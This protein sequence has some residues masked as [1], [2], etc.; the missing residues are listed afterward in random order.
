MKHFIL[1]G[2]IFSL[3]ACA[4]P[5]SQ[6]VENSEIKS[7]DEQIEELKS[8]VSTLEAQVQSASNSCEQTVM[9]GTQV[10]GK[11]ETYQMTVADSPQSLCEQFRSDCDKEDMSGVTY[12]DY[13]DMQSGK[14]DDVICVK[15][16]PGKDKDRT[17]CL[18]VYDITER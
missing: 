17:I 2:L 16:A 18:S 8:K 4:S 14:T 1:T 10:V 7:K 11:V 5:K 13:G 12:F 6:T 9:E 3:A 15:N